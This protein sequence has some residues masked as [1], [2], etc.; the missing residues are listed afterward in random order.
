MLKPDALELI[1]P[2]KPSHIP[3]FEKTTIGTAHFVNFNCDS[4]RYVLIYFENGMTGKDCYMIENLIN[5]M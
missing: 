5:F 2:Q 1:L 3:I 4:Y